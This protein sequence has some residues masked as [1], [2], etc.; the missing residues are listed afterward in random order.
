MFIFFHFQLYIL[1]IYGFSRILTARWDPYF[2]EDSAKYF[3]FDFF[4]N[5]L[6]EEISHVFKIMHLIPYLTIEDA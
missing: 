6:T 4:R 3:V 2:F 5:D 1:F